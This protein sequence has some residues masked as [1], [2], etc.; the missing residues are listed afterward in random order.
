MMYYL[1]G[2]NESHKDSIFVSKTSGVVEEWV[3]SL[4][5]CDVIDTVSIQR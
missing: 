5:K 1:K 3:T 2:L 4:V